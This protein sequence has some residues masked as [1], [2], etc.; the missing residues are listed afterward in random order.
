MT[1]GPVLLVFP[2]IGTAGDSWR[3]RQAQVDEWQGAYPVLDV[4]SECR[5][6]LSWLN[7]NP[8]RKKTVRGMPKFLNGWLSRAVD[9]GRV[10]YASNLGGGVGS[11]TTALAAADAVLL[12]RQA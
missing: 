2:T 10:N 9:S 3:L 5:K 12:R 7:A 6:A 1:T 8:G 11:R 4:L